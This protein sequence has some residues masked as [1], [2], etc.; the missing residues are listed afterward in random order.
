[1]IVTLTSLSVRTVPLI[2]FLL[3]SL[4]FDDIE[5]C[6]RDDGLYDLFYINGELYSIAQTL[7]HRNRL[8]VLVKLEKTH[9]VAT[10]FRSVLLR[11]QR[12]ERTFYDALVRRKLL[13]QDLAVNK[14][15]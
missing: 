13:V 14:R 11:M 4:L 6:L 10:L 2:D 7:F 5:S 9:T 8:Q 12:I 3:F 1:M 15:N